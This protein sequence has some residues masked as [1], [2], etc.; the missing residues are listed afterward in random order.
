MALVAIVLSLLPGVPSVLAS[1]KTNGLSFNELRSQYDAIQN[2]PSLSDEAKVKNT[3]D[4]MFLADLQSR[5]E[6]SVMDIG[7]LFS[8]KDSTTPGLAKYEMGITAITI[9]RI[10]YF[11]TPVDSFTYSPKYES[12]SIDGDHAVVVMTP[13]GSTKLHRGNTEETLYVKHQVELKRD[14]GLWQIASNQYRNE[15]TDQYPEGTDLMAVARDYGMIQDT[16]AE[17]EREWL[18]KTQS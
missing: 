7:F 14:N 8:N 6:L 15:M 9:A 3:V 18:A 17:K 5:K 13:I 16:A 10:T 4:T 11:N 1:G 2:D 12:I